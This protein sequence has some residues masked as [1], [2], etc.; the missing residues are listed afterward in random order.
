M[1]FQ[2][3]MIFQTHFSPLETETAY[4]GQLISSADRPNDHRNGIWNNPIHLV[5]LS[6]FGGSYMNVKE[7][8]TKRNGDTEY[9]CVKMAAATI[10]TILLTKS[11]GRQELV[12]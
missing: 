2:R 3:I 4:L 5:I 1:L 12:P 6:V 8:N 10:S 11:C 7:Y 9:E